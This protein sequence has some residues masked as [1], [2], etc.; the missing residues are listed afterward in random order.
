MDG[1]RAGRTE[2][3]GGAGT[4]QSIEGNLDANL[5]RAKQARTPLIGGCLENMQ[6]LSAQRG[7]WIARQSR[8]HG[9][10]IEAFAGAIGVDHGD[11]GG[12]RQWRE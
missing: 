6:A 10:I 9:R 1:E 3:S 11:G 5:D 7:K 2:H 8:H 12:R 4:T